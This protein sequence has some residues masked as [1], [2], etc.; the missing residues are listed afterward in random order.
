ML[1]IA[2]FAVTCVVALL[3]SAEQAQAGVIVSPVTV[4]SNSLGE[5]SA[6]FDSPRMINQAGLSSSFTSGVTDFSTYIASSPVHATVE[7][8]GGT[9][10]SST[11]NRTGMI[12]FDLGST[13]NINQVALWQGVAGNEAGVNAFRVFT[14]SDSAFTSATLVGSYNAAI[15]TDG[16]EIAQVFDVTDTSARYI[17]LQID[18]NHGHGSLTG[19][20]EFAV[21]ATTSSVNAVPEPTSFAIFG[22]GAI[23]MAGMGWRRKL[24]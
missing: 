5:Y 3:V 8:A 20:G 15:G 4:V 17:R 24:K 14:S 22:L 9:W 19:L 16:P 7:S 6:A 1:R 13:L 11:G 23:V 10:L 21:D 18:S 2:K 12:D